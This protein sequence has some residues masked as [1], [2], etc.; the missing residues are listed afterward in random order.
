[1]QYSKGSDSCHATW[2]LIGK[3]LNL[4]TILSEN[5]DAIISDCTDAIRKR[6]GER[7]SER[8]IS[9]LMRTTSEIADANFAALV[10]DDFSKIDHF[11]E[12]I[13]ELR[14]HSGFA[15]SEVQQAF[16]LHRTV[17]VCLLTKRFKGGDLDDALNRLNPRIC[18]RR[19]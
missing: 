6:C 7:Y 13:T 12:K 2:R 5:R 1:M 15:L 3:G 10:D 14:L 4:K 16:D 19:T 8:S 17:M 18:T 11:I 9:E